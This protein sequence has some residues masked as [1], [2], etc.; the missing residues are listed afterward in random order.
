MNKTLAKSLGLAGILAFS[1]G[2]R[3]N[4]FYITQEGPRDNTGSF[5][6]VFDLRDYGI[7]DSTSH[8]IRAVELTSRRPEI[9]L[10]GDG[11]DPNLIK[12]NYAFKVYNSINI[13]EHHPVKLWVMF[14]GVLGYEAYFRRR[15]K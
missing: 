13:P 3:E 15:K 8:E 1:F 9:E 6:D 7:K 2:L 12:E 10:I 5:C 4:L 14:L 11:L